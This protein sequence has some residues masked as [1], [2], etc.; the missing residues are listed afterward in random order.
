MNQLLLCLV[1]HGQW[2]GVGI[3]HGGEEG[4]GKQ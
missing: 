1:G 4:F 3:S 2:R